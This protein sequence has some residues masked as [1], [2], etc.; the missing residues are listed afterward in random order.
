MPAFSGLFAPHWRS[1]ARGVIVGLTR[2][3]NQG[4]P[5]AGGARGD[6][7]PDP[8]G[9]RRDERR[10]RGVRQDLRTAELKVDGGMVGNETL[11]QFQADILGVP[12]VRPVVA[13]TTA[14]GA[15]YAAGLAVGFW[16][17]TQEIR[18]QWAEGGRWV[19]AHRRRRTRTAV[20]AMAQ[21]GHPHVR[22]GRQRILTPD[23]DPTPRIARSVDHDAEVRDF[24]VSSACRELSV[25]INTK[26][27]R[28]RKPR[29]QSRSSTAVMSCRPTSVIEPD[30]DGY[31]LKV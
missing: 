15:A 5:R 11:M 16:S 17:S 25:M 20:P 31:T 9:A 12:V 28:P 4:P 7:V 19:P 13:E 18:D 10:L 30:S 8:R 14:L 24:G 27:G 6:R 1:D 23:L 26:A 3:V 21:G 29:N 22:L 2:F